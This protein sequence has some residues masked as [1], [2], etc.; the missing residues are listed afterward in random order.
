[1]GF[2]PYHLLHCKAILFLRLL[3]F[4]SLLFFEFI[5]LF[6]SHRAVY[7]F[8]ILFLCVGKEPQPYTNDFFFFV[9][10]FIASVIWQG[11]LFGCV[12]SG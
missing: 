5:Y 6:S 10:I 9:H 11:W 12:G 7:H 4:F 8:I 2:F 3:I 1:M